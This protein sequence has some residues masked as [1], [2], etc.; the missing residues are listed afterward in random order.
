MKKLIQF[1]MPPPSWRLPA[2]LM[3]GIITGI[4]FHIFYASNAVSY[5]SDK[6]ETC[7]N[8]H[9]M[10]PQF[11]TWQKSSHGRDTN[12]NDCHVPHNNFIEKYYFKASDGLRHA[13]MFTFRLEPQV[14]QI[15]E[16]GQRAV[17][18]NCIR[19]HENVI[20]PISMRALTTESTLE[21]G[22]RFCW[23]CHREVPHGRVNSL[24]S[25]PNA[26]VPGLNPIIP[27]WLKESNKNR[28]GEK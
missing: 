14:I 26:Q 25:T 8:C 20:H 5:L 4:S 7:I 21:N 16:A 23:D 2:L 24:S 15:K 19:C 18:E 3:S 6:P 12:C 11:A 1:F 9:V 13:T 22:E 28:K 10:V 17:Q 27:D